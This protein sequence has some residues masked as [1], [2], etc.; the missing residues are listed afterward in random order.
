[1][2]KEWAYHQ[3]SIADLER[4]FDVLSHE[5][6]TSKRAYFRYET[7]G[8]NSL[9]K[10][11]EVTVYRILFRQFT[12]IFI[13]LL[14]FA[15][16][17]SYFIDGF[18]QALLLF[19]III[20]NVALGFFQEFKAER[21][22]DELKKS[23]RSKSK[24]IRNGTIEIIDNQELVP[25]DVVLFQS[26][27][28]IPADIRLIE[29]EDLRINEASLTGESLPESKNTGSLNIDTVLA[30]RTNMAY[31]STIVIS[32]KGKGIVVATGKDTEFGKIASLID[33]TDEITPLEKR[34]SYLAK[35]L[36]VAAL[37]AGVSIFIMGYFRNYEILPLLTLVISLI[38]AAVPESLPTVITLSLAIGVSRMAKKKAIVRKLAVIEAL[39]TTDIIATDKTGTLT[40]NELTVENTFSLNKGKI[41]KTDFSNVCDRDI[42]L[43][44]SAVLCTSVLDGSKKA[45]FGDPLDVALVRKAKE[46]D[47]SLSTRDYERIIEFPFDSDRKFMAV[48][49]KNEKQNILIAKGIVEKIISFCNLSDKE[50]EIILTQ[51]NYLSKD[52]FKVIAIADKKIGEKSSSAFSSMNFLGLIAFA[53]EPSSGIKE[54]I[55]KV[56]DSGIRPIIITGDH[57]ETARYVA[58]R[59]GLVIDDDE[60]ITGQELDKM[61]KWELKK[62][63]LKVKIFSRI[64]P[65][66][67]LNI[68]KSLQD[69]GYSVA[70]TG[71]GV[72][73]APALKEAAVGI[74]MGIKGTDVARESSDIILSNDHYGTII[75]AIEYGRAIYDNI[76]NI[77]TLLLIG[78][79]DE[80]FLVSAVFLLDLPLPLTTLQILWIN[81]VT[82]SLLA[83]AIVFEEPSLKVLKQKP[84]KDNSSSFRRPVIL[85]LELSIVSF[86]LSLIMYIFQM[87][88]TIAHARTMIF[89]YLVLTC[90]AYVLSI[91][92]ERRF[93]Q[94]PAS[95]LK[96]KFLIISIIATLGAQSILFF[97]PLSNIFSIAALS[98]YDV[99]ILLIFSIVAFVLA[100][101]LRYANDKKYVD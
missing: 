34:I 69:A 18:A 12:S 61:G 81:L 67:K 23:F 42:K 79:F 52:G 49:I 83:I 25:G 60:I 71:D 11:K 5:G 70:V 65:S 13:L 63:L 88:G 96:N 95:F 35:I 51:A 86:S 45:L 99:V 32:G 36:A 76:R 87:G 73:D 31:G 48:S 80:I 29:T 28:M 55:K 82:E 93:W 7:H 37:I 3:W 92:S 33:K 91:R 66:D 59:I 4:H 21:S 9:N 94:K 20:A 89:S 27:D 43:F 54:A 78:N 97:P 74:A 72:N 15:M 38:V 40:N 46:L 22:L 17:I 62:A 57:P 30:D 101:V 44:K 8:A 39:G 53:D 2:K 90:I 98:L 41:I 26:G 85:A 77:I 68:V 50:K 16:A 24:V 75:S 6:L 64:S 19:L 84:R 58:N 56:I 10:F 100:E 1:M 14:F 47:I